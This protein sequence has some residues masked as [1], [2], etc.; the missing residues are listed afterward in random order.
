MF[1]NFLDPSSISLHFG[2][3]LRKDWGFMDSEGIFGL[4]GYLNP[5]HMATGITW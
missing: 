4:Y 5:Q 1:G 3:K 2:S